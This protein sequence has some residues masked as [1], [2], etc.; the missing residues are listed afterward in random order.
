MNFMYLMQN[1]DF[2]EHACRPKTRR[3]IKFNS[4]V[5]VVL[6]PSVK[7]MESMKN[8]LWWSNTDYIS[9]HMSSC[10]E[11]RDCMCEHSPHLTRVQ[12]M[13]IL[14][15]PSTIDECSITINCSAQI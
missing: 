15:Q 3:K 6:I 13:K 12:A 14:Y 10:K 5:N 8:D 1:M 4:V 2:I 9:F 11:L 7:E